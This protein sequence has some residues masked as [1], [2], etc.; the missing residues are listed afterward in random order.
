MGEWEP[1]VGQDPSESLQDEL[2]AVYA[3]RRK[4][5]GAFFKLTVAVLA[6]F[7]LV[8]LVD[9][10]RSVQQ[11]NF[12]G[13]SVGAEALVGRTVMAAVDDEAWDEMLELQAAQNE[14]GL[15][16][17]LQRGRLFVLNPGTRVRI[18]ETGFGNAVVQPLDGRFAGRTGRVASQGLLPQRG[19]DAPDAPQ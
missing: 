6:L 13:L 2:E 16:F 4:R 14:V 1:G 10:V 17:L 9:F 8:E 11:P 18:L 15:N 7:V 3:Q 5:L 12:D 19:V